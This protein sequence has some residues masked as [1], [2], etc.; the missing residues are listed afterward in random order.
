MTK[1]SCKNCLHFA[2]IVGLTDSAGRSQFKPSVCWGM[3]SK[4]KQHKMVNKDFSC[5]FF[6]KRKEQNNA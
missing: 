2:K 1:Y 5:R 3:C 4:G 6:E